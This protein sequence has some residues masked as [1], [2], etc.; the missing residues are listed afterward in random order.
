MAGAIVF[1]SPRANK[2]S[3]NL[4]NSAGGPETVASFT[5]CDLTS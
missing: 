3:M 4:Y 2:D 5:R 1:Q